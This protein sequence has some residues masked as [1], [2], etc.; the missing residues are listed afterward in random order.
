MRGGW[1]GG[2]GEGVVKGFEGVEPESP[3][4][5]PSEALGV[6]STSIVSRAYSGHER[7]RVFLSPPAPSP[8]ERPITARFLEKL[9]LR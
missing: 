1:G 9:T 5:R 8:P 4:T 7:H 2:G 3:P 6:G